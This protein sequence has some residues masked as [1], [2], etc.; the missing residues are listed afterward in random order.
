VATPT[1]IDHVAALSDAEPRPRWAQRHYLIPEIA[2]TLNLSDDTVRRLFEN[3][4]DIVRLGKL[5]SG[6]KRRYVTLS[7]PEDVLERVYRRITRG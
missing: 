4:P 7:I 2:K 1:K 3:E 5:H 6:R